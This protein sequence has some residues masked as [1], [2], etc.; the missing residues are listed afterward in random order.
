MRSVLAKMVAATTGHAFEKLQLALAK[1]RKAMMA[2]AGRMAESRG[3]RLRASRGSLCSRPLG[4]V[5]SEDART[6]PRLHG[7][8]DTALRLVGTDLPTGSVSYSVVKNRAVQ[9]I[10][11]V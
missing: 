9:A 7:A 11:F 10:S 8:S 4:A 1:R 3:R 6:S 2:G 5:F